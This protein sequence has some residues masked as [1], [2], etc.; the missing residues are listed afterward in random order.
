[1]GSTIDFIESRAGIGD[2]AHS[3]ILANGSDTG[4][5]L[6]FGVKGLDTAITVPSGAVSRN[7]KADF[8]STNSSNIPAIAIL[9]VCGM[10]EAASLPPL[11]V[12]IVACAF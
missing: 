1:M 10:A 6:G 11:R 2:Q 5:G 7:L 3:C 4:H 9:P 8:A 12:G